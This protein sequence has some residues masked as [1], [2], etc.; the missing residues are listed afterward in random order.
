[1]LWAGRPYGRQL[2]ET[3]DEYGVTPI[4][5]VSGIDPAG[6]PTAIIKYGTIFMRLYFGFT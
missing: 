6:S 2:A 3:I 4:G 5:P 1:M